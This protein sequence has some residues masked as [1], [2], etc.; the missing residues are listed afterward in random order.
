MMGIAMLN[1]STLARVKLKLEV[2]LQHNM[3]CAYVTNE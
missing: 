1:P 3:D 2:Y